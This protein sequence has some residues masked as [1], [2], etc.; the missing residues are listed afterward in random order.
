MPP[1]PKGQPGHGQPGLKITIPG[2][3]PSRVSFQHRLHPKQ[4]SS[5]PQLMGHA[6]G[7][8]STMAT[9]PHSSAA[10]EHT[11]I[12]L[13]QLKET[14]P[15]DSSPSPSQ[16]LPEQRL[17]LPA[18]GCCF[19]QSCLSAPLRKMQPDLAFFNK[20]FSKLKQEPVQPQVE[21][22]KGSNYEQ[23]RGV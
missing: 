9:G 22:M 6:Q 14:R 1:P 10:P 17:L 4:P 18:P 12:A 20:H 8:C 19:A 21:E 2:C 15:A 3:F 7:G 11:N 23:N 13:L 5:K 16:P